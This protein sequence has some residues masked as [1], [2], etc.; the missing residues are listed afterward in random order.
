MAK[1][2]IFTDSSCDLSTE[3]RKANNIEYFYFGLVVDGV[4][5]KADLVVYDWRYYYVKYDEFRPGR[6]GKYY[7]NEFE[8]EPYNLI[9]LWTKTQVSERAFNPFLSAIDP[10]DSHC[11]FDGTSRYVD[12]GATRI[13]S[14]NA[15]YYV[16]DSGTDEILE[17]YNIDQTADGVDTEDR[18]AKIRALNLV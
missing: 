15:G 14:R 6:Y 13:K 16:V 11:V 5:Y 2:Q 4:E 10:D 1:Y 3:L 12:R 8:A 18:V 7:W 9:V 17:E